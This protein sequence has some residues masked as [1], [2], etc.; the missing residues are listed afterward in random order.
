MPGIEMKAGVMMSGGSQ[1][2]YNTPPLALACR[3]FPD[4]PHDC[5]FSL[6]FVVVGDVVVVGG[7]IVVGGGGGGDFVVAVE[8]IL[9]LFCTHNVIVAGAHALWT[10]YRWHAGASNRAA[11]FLPGRIHPHSTFLVVACTFTIFF[12]DAIGPLTGSMHRLRRGR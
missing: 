10:P 1:Q 12:D 8:R 3:W 4:F 2:C 6:P 9:S 7:V 5:F 11:T